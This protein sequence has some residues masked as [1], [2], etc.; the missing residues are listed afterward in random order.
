MWA[1]TWARGHGVTHRICH[2]VPTAYANLSGDKAV[3]RWW[4][5]CVGRV[6]GAGLLVDHRICHSVSTAYLNCSGVK[7][8]FSWWLTCVGKVLGAGGAGG[9]ARGARGDAH[10]AQSTPLWLR[11]DRRDQDSGMQ[12]E[13][14][15]ESISDTSLCLRL[16]MVSS[17]FQ[18]SEGIFGW[19]FVSEMKKIIIIQSNQDKW[20]LKGPRSFFLL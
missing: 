15:V 16:H 7:A 20:E 2:S 12:L 9:G 18:K 6:L 4:Y 14:I 13:H 3:Y 17:M 5:T 11:V 8:V 10:S 19:R 1:E